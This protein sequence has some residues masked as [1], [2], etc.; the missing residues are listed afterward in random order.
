MPDVREVYDMVTQQT[1]PK[2]GALERQ[3]DR[4]RRAARNR[5]VGTFAL[6]A[7]LVV[8]L[9]V[10]ALVRMPGGTPPLSSD[11]VSTTPTQTVT[12]GLDRQDRIV[13][14][15][16]GDI[17][18]VVDGL[19][20]DAYGLSLASGNG[21]AIAFVT[22]ADGVDQIAT[23]DIEGNGMRILGP[24]T[25]PAMSP[26]GSQIAFVQ[27]EDIYVM[28]SDGANVQ[29]LTFDPRPDEFPEW[30]PDGSTIVYD[31]VGRQ[32]AD[33]SGFS[34]TSAIMT[35]PA[36]GGTPTQISR[37]PVGDGE[38]SYA[39]GGDRIAFRRNFDIW[40]MNADGSGARL[41]HHNRTQ[42]SGGGVADAPE[43]SPDGTK[44]A[45]TEYSDSWRPYLRLGVESGDMPIEIVHIVDVATGEVTRL[46]HL[47]MA[48]FYNS[49]QWLPTGDALLL[50]VARRS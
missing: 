39:P 12:P 29:R 24:G 41:V 2:P 33:E 35:V 10:F 15:L 40:V 43:W 49:P 27:N 30:S 38:P 46:G 50:N 4:R 31:N 13:V 36:S 28:R 25:Q 6:V 3:W 22:S 44:I 16:D 19:P 32:P 1:P 34:G 9:A 48:T 21:V 23:I 8:V 18:H 5:K 11:S 7:A 14:G 42:E 17:R 37:N 47:G 26:D 20:E 45:F